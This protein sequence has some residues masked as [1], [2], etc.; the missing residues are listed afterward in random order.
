M[1]KPLNCRCAN[2]SPALVNKGGELGDSAVAIKV[3]DDL[4]ARFGAA[5]ELPLREQVAH[6]LINKGVIL[7]R[8]GNSA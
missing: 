2:R 4:L 7:G 6:A 5:T 3:Y 8:L 1:A